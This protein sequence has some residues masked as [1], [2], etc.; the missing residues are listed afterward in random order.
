[1]AYTL[2]RNLHLRIDS[3]LTAN[4]KYNLERLDTLGATFTV[5]S[6]DEL[7]IRSKGNIAIEPES[8]DI[9]GS[10]TGGTVTIGTAD[11]EIAT[12]A[13][14][15]ASLQLNNPLSLLDKASG[16]TKYLQLRY[17]SDTSG[18][19]DTTANRILSLDL[20]GADRN[21][22][23]AGNLVLSGGGNLT[24]SAST[25]SSLTLPTTGTL[26]TLAGSEVLTNKTIDA[27][28]NT[29]SNIT[30]SSVSSSA[31]IAYSKLN[32]LASITNADIAS[33]AAIAGTK[34]SP[35]F[36][37][38]QI[39]TS[40]NLQFTH[41]G[42][43]TTL[44]P[45]QSGQG[46]NLTLTLPSAAGSSGFVLT[47]DGTGNLSWAA[48]G[49]GTITSVAL[50]MP[51]EFS[52]SGS[53]VT[54]AGT[55]SVTKADQS[56]NLVYAG[57]STGAAAA[58]SFRTLAGADLP[59]AIDAAKIADG[60]VSS[61]EFQY[62]SGVTSDIQTQISSKQPLDADLTAVAALSTTGLVARTGSGT[63]TTRTLA[64]GTG[65]S[66][67]NGDGVSANPTVSLANTA[68]TAGTYGSTTESIQLVVDAQGRITSASNQTIALSSAQVSDFSEASQDAVG[69]ILATSATIALAYNDSTPQIDA[70]IVTDSITNSHIN[71]S[72]AI[73]YSKLNLSSSIVNADVAAGAAIAYS[74]L[75]LT[76]SLVNADVS[77]SAAIAYSKL[78]LTAS[79]LD[80]D[81]SP[82]AAISYSKLSLAGSIVNADISNSAA[83]AYSKLNLATSIVN[84]DIS[85]SAAI[86]YSKLALTGA[87][88]NADI[89]ASAA[90]A[91]SKLNLATSIVNADISASAAIAYSKLA[92]SNSIVDAD[93]SSGA[94]IAYSKLAAL[95]A[96]RALVSNG[97]G[98][99]SVSATTATELSY[100]SGVTSAIQTQLN[101]ITAA[102]QAHDWITAD[103]TTKTITHSLGTRD[104]RVEVYDKTDGQTILPDTVTRTSTSAVELTAS[105]APGAAGWRVLIT[106]VG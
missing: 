97:S 64:A 60:S 85:A 39:S 28:S 82:S 12:L 84:A 2:S 21:L 4:A 23:L 98:A 73:A 99:V 63:A 104:I 44:Q 53:P 37:A 45:A 47:T 27:A 59:S 91:Y 3:N 14:Y 68:V 94:A 92:L 15:A 1:M 34:I 102:N 80:A 49:Q 6:T 54:S 71:S 33:G 81:I 31:A 61:T 30:N 75:S 25:N 93:I 101:T 95:T 9:G 38:Q 10:G 17:K 79:I 88:V 90:I 52:V 77:G 40:S 106:R 13:I 96:D 32:L 18:S 50:S 65:L 70:T 78:A 19:V 46:T 8:A 89:S 42:Y 69:G 56:A 67:A 105:E 16:G 103:G 74:K 7:D 83:I 100:V 58:P 35:A 62:L 57:P 11:H 20:E 86:A 72:A 5:D 87:V 26:A 55:L 24:L 66:V 41:S 51:A 43:T 76:G 22:V 36:G 48:T 29:L